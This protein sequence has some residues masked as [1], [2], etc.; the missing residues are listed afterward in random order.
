MESVAMSSIE[1]I[2]LNSVKGLGPVRIKQLIDFYGSAEEVFRRPPDE[3]RRDG[4]VPASCIAGLFG[5]ELT[6]VAEAQAAR[7]EKEGVQIFTLASERYP[8]YLREIFA[9][10][11]VLFVRGDVS[12][13][14]LPCIAVVGT[15]SPT[16]YGKTVTRS[17]TQELVGQGLVIASGL[18][19]GI[20]T[21]AHETCLERGG[22][23][24]AVLGCG[25]DIPYPAENA[26]LARRIGETGIL[27]SEFPMGTRPEPF[28]FPRRNRIISGLAAGVLVV[29]GGEKSGGLI[30]ASYA[31]A[32]GRD[33]FAVPGPITSPLSAGPFNLIREGAIPA[34]SGREI[35]DA[36]ALFGSHRPAGKPGGET[37]PAAGEGIQLSLLSESER[38]IYE[39]LSETPRR[40]DEL[41][42][43]AGRPV[44]QLF[45]ALLMLELK[46]L[47][48]QLS[49]QL[50]IRV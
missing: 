28:N 11:P 7:A 14:T 40:M 27:I 2:A 22:R 21:I 13:F 32:Q 20:D 17:L 45:D 47:V 44:M 3:L 38:N 5:K 46:G 4:I 29:E 42:A 26:A 9:P 1:W 41:S 43:L 16:V 49:G 34:R 10:P 48:R 23:T 30:T 18:A 8:P 39:T 6:A 24:I 35:A 15:R 25:I 19:R 50:Y 37:P 36:L 12:A 33:V 31:L